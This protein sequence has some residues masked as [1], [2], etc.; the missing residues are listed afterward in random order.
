MRQTRLMSKNKRLAYASQIEEIFESADC[1]MLK[2]FRSSTFYTSSIWEASG[3]LL[4]KKL[5][6]KEDNCIVLLLKNT[7]TVLKHHYNMKQQIL[8]SQRLG[9]ETPHEAFTNA[10]HGHSNHKKWKYFGFLSQHGLVKIFYD[11]RYF[12]QFYEGNALS[13]HRQR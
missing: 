10:F 7:S 1:K 5:L 8:F 2:I 4:E 9:N 6:Y 11:N 12:S 3:L 13:F